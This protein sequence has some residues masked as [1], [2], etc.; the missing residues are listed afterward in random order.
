MKKYDLSKMRKYMEIEYGD[1][2]PMVRIPDPMPDM[3]ALSDITR[4]IYHQGSSSNFNH[5]MRQLYI[6]PDLMRVPV[7]RAYLE[8]WYPVGQ[9]V[10]L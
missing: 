8:D 4:T 2:A 5:A 1:L 6:Y 10:V 7:R 9:R 3:L